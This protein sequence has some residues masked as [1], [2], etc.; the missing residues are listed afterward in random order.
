MREADETISDGLLIAM[1]LKG[2]PQTFLPFSI[3]VDNRTKLSFAEFKKA[4]R[5][6]ED[7]QNLN[8]TSEKN[9]VMGQCTKS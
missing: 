3:M 2:L 6:F 9:Y 5:N 1:I 8:R 7:N 4:Q